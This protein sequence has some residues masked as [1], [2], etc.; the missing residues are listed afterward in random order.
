MSI[1]LFAAKINVKHY[2]ETNNKE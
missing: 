2:I 1:V